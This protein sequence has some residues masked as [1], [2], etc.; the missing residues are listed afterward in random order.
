MASIQ[1]K[2]NGWYCQFVYRGKRRTFAVG[3]VPRAE[4]EAKASQVEYLLM[5][6]EQRLIELPAG[7]DIVALLRRDGASAAEELPAPKAEPTLGNLRDRYLETHEGS[8]EPHTLRGIR[9]HFRLI[10][11]H[12]GEGFHIRTLSLE[13]LQG[14]VNG[15]AKAKGRRG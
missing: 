14:Y 2:G 12:F 5:R 10:A 1:Q 3:R 9:K 8:L 7:T 13:D 15:R 11:R 4:A 6:L